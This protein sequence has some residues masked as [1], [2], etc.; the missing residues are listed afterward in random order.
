MRP[1]N[2][3]DQQLHG[4]SAQEFTILSGFK[5]VKFSVTEHGIVIPKLKVANGF[6]LTKG[7]VY[8]IHLRLQ[9]QKT[10]LEWTAK[11]TAAGAIHTSSHPIHIDV[12][13]M[14]GL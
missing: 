5:P 12:N 3:S 7:H 10:D 11:P 8:E 9:M 4:Y 13:Y 6:K 2:Q 1:C 14:C